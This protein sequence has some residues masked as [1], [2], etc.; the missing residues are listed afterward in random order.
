MSNNRESNNWEWECFEKWITK[1]SFVVTDFGPLAG[2]VSEFSI[3]RDE[4]L[5]LILNTTSINAPKQTSYISPGTVW[6]PSDQVKFENSLLNYSVIAHGVIQTSRSDSLILSESERSERS[7]TKETSSLTALE[8]I[9]VPHSEPHFIIEWIENMGGSFIWPHSL[10]DLTLIEKRRTLRSPNG[11]IVLISKTGFEGLPQRT[12]NCCA[13]ISV[14]GFELFVGTLQGLKP[15]N[16]KKPGFILYK[17]NL[18]EELRTKIRECLSFSLGIYFIYLGFTAFDEHWTPISFRALSAEALRNNDHRCLAILPGPL[19]NRFEWEIN[20]EQLQKIVVGLYSKYDTYQLQSAFWSYW[21]AVAAPVHMAAAHFGAAIEALQNTYISHH[22][23]SF[24]KTILNKDLWSTL[25]GK[26][27]EF[28]ST[29]NN[30]GEDKQIFL[31]KLQNLNH[32]PQ[33][34]LMSRFLDSIGIRIGEVENSA[35]NYRNRGAHGGS[36]NSDNAI[37]VIRE[38]KA[39]RILMNRIILAIT[40]GNTQYYDYYSI[41]TPTRGTPTRELKEPIPDEILDN[42]KKAE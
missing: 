8:G 40:N 41:G 15:S 42:A 10:S 33:S 6:I 7:V 18:N 9:L 28:I 39:L 20:P 36:V 11:E 38:N 1:E 25:Y 22:K 5:N 27:I 14:D 35:W 23:T 34:V 16:I 13:H 37:K 17:G 12:S 3:R 19:G 26:I 4:N 29:L 2:S 21:H 32:A 31:N 30:L 24:N